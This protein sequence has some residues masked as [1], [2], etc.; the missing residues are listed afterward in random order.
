MSPLLLR[1]SFVTLARILCGSVGLASIATGCSLVNSYEDVAADRPIASDA[2]DASVD[3]GSSDVISLRDDGVVETSVPEAGTPKGAIVIGGFVGGDAGLVPVLTALAPENGAELPRARE[4]MNVAAVQYDGLR[5]LWYVFE[6]GGSGA[7]PAPN[8]PIFLHVRTLDTTTGEWKELQKLRIPTL[9]SFVTIAILRERIGYVAYRVNDAG[10]GYS[11]VTLD[12]S[13]PS[14]VAI[15]DTQP[16]DAAPIGV[17]GTRSTVGLGG[18]VNLVR[19]GPCPDAGG[20][21]VELVHVIV[22]PGAPPTISTTPTSIGPVAGSPAFGSFH[23]NGPN[24]VI[25]MRSSFGPPGPA[26]GE[27]YSPQLNTPIGVKASEVVS[28]PYL[29]PLAFSECLRTALLVETNQDLF[30]HA[31]PF[32]TEGVGS[33]KVSTGH[34]GQG[35]YFEPF[36]STVLTPFSQ[37][38]GFELTAF[39]LHGTATAPE[40]TRRDSPAWV[41]PAELRPTIVATR[42]PLPIVCP[43]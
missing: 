9:V 24:D 4:T 15:N 39:T 25:M 22:P 5:D 17:I 7:Y 3:V 41:P 28:G 32:G 36:T 12:T 27:L 30:V 35:V 14:V 11:F 10:I 20:S 16:I 40:L 34:S 43:P 38:P 1:R 33:A 23:S 21:C 42:Q 13:T 26:K 18:V 8:D 19:L 6:S 31:I 37:G 2:G 29:K